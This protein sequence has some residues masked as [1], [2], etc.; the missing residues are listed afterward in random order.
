MIGTGFNY[1]DRHWSFEPATIFQTSFA[2]FGHLNGFQLSGQALCNLR[3]SLP[4]AP[5]LLLK[6][7]KLQSM[8]VVS[9]MPIGTV[10]SSRKGAYP[11]LFVNWNYH[12]VHC[13]SC[14]WKCIGR[15]C[16]IDLWMDTSPICTIRCIA[17]WSFCT[18]V[19]EWET[20]SIQ[21]L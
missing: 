8:C 3:S 12:K 15:L 16:L 5:C 11:S 20:R 7:R 18:K 21:K 14:G 2:G 13:T 9:R 1:W 10:N 6:G 17:K 4:T 19:W